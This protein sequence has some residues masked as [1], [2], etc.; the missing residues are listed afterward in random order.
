MQVLR[1]AR[2][3]ETKHSS[4]IG[5]VSSSFA[6]S[7]LGRV[8]DKEYL[9]NNQLIGPAPVPLEQYVDAVQRQH[10]KPGNGKSFL[11]E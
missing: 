5:T 11:S 4:T 8:R 1:K 3:L 10:T 6:L 9:D 7:E 2:L